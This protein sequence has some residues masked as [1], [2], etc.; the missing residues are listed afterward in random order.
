MSHPTIL[1]TSDFVFEHFAERYDQ[2][3]DSMYNHLRRV[4]EGVRPYGERFE[5]AGWLH[6]VVEDTP[7][8]L[9]DLEEMGYHNDIIVAV[10]LLSRRKGE[11]YAEYLDRLIA[12]RNPIATA[13][14]ISD[15]FDN[16]NPKR[17]AVLPHYMRQSLQKRYA[18]V[19]PRLLSLAGE[20]L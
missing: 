15:Q 8:T 19:L 6:D 5:H 7:I 12:G 17:F 10:D 1:E 3:G 11:T 20:I 14:K 9:R 13:V 16:T 4:A 2:G 18:G